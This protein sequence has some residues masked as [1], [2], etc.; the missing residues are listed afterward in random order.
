MRFVDPDGMWGRTADQ[1]ADSEE[2]KEN[3]E[4]NWQSQK[5]AMASSLQKESKSG[6]NE[7]LPKNKQQKLIAAG[8]VL[9]AAPEGIS[10]VIGLGLMATGGFL[11]LWY[12]LYNDGTHI[13]VIHSKS[14]Q[15]PFDNQIQGSQD[16]DGFP[17]IPPK[18]LLWSIIFGSYGVS[19]LHNN[20]PVPNIPQTQQSVDNK[21]Y[22]S[23]TRTPAR[24][25]GLQITSPSIPTHSVDKV[26]FHPRTIRYH[27]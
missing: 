21:T 26:Y 23:P 17:R 11:Y 8:L 19:E 25:N 10:S 14:G 22:L 5:E 27:E 15:F 24:A 18:G 9:T 20:S 4:A 13:T 6:D 7:E 3:E 12:Y 16:D 2:E 1:G